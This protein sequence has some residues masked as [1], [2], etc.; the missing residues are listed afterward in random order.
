MMILLPPAHAAAIQG[1]IVLDVGNTW[2]GNRVLRPVV[3][4]N[5]SIYMMWYSGGS[6][7][8]HDIGLATSADGKTWTRYA[9]NPEFAPTPVMARGLTGEWDSNSID[10]AWVL[11]EGN[12]YKMWYSGQLWNPDGSIKNYLIGYATSSDGISWSK[13]PGNPVL[14]VGAPGSWDDKWAWRPIV[15]RQGSS[16][17]MYYRGVSTQPE[18][19][20]KAGLATSP[21]GIHWTKTTVLTM[22]PGGS[23]WDAFSRSTGALNVGSVMRLGDLYIMGYTSIKTQTSPQEIGFASSPDG[24]NWTPFAG[25]PAITY[26]SSGWDSGGVSRPLVV[27]VGDNYYVYYDGSTPD[28]VPTRIA[29]AI[30]PMSQYPIPEYS[31]NATAMLTAVVMVLMAFLMMRPRLGHR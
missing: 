8:V 3:V 4:Y 21:D 6:G 15:I 13:Y 1:R 23:G 31:S 14:T 25:N 26:G 17:V 22:P 29:L 19:Q 18:T 12:Q 7:G 10:E 20:A 11:R 2:D 9:R 24:M 28:L 27:V 16:Y 5:G 30:L